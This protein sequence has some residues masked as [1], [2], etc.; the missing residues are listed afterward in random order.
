M[1]TAEKGHCGPL[2]GRAGGWQPPLTHR[3][4]SSSGIGA[5]TQGV[6]IPDG[7]GGMEESF[8]VYS[9]LSLSTLSK[10]LSISH[11]PNTELL[12]FTEEKQAH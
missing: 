4:I 5:H 9:T 12:K 6:S 3:A 11:L 10:S 1:G 2:E 7:G 8:Q